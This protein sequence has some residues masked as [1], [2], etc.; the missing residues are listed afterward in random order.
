[1]I[2]NPDHV[3]HLAATILSSRPE[4]EA[5]HIK[6]A[7]GCARAI[8]TEA[9]RMAEEDHAI[10]AGETAKIETAKIAET[11]EKKPGAGEMQDQ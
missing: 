10:V 4:P 8:L 6:A 11:G 5:H 3:A 1:M 2:H 9:H 7:I